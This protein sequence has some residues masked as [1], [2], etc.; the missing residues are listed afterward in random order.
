M[1]TL[2]KFFGRSWTIDTGISDPSPDYLE[3]LDHFH[4]ALA[5]EYRP[6]AWNLVEEGQRLTGLLGEDLEVSVPELLNIRM[7]CSF[8]RK[9]MEWKNWGPEYALRPEHNTL[10][11]A[12]VLQL[13]SIE[14]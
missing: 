5:H 3:L 12:T 7:M 6:S 2:T 14:P 4:T 10:Q 8:L 11:Y 9:M 13:L 1:I